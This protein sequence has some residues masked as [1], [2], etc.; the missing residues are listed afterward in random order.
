MSISQLAY[1]DNGKKQQPIKLYPIL[2]I[3]NRNR[4]MCKMENVYQ[5]VHDLLAHKKHTSVFKSA[6]DHKQL[7]PGTSSEYTFFTMCL[8]VKYVVL[9]AVIF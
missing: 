6:L 8:Y 2:C 5:H 9:Y 1:N 7:V 3:E 4:T